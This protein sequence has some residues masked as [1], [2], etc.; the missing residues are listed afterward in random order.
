MVDTA[1]PTPVPSNVGH[2][3]ISIK[4]SSTSTFQGFPDGG[5]TKR[6][7]TRAKRRKLDS[8]MDWA[9]LSVV[10]WLETCL[11]G[12]NPAGMSYKP[13]EVDVSHR[14]TDIHQEVVRGLSSLHWL[15]SR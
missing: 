15:N 5:I 13:F 14:E 11:P 2:T 1:S 10:K 9:F 7:Q 6:D 4:A 8:E 12:P 3:P